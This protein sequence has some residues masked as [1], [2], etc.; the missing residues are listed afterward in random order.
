MYNI[1][2]IILMFNG[3]KYIDIVMQPSPLSITTFLSSLIATLYPLKS[4]SPKSPTLVLG[5]HHSTFSKNLTISV[6]YISGIV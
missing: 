4:N 3:I 6:P 5:N 1:K 2:F